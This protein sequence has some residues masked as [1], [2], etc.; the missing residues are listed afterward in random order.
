MYCQYIFLERNVKRGSPERRKM[1]K[2]GGL[3]LQKRKR[4]REGI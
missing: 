3:N 2:I 4:F 1:I